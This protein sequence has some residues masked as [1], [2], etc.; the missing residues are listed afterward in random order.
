MEEGKAVCGPVGSEFLGQSRVLDLRDVGCNWCSI[1]DAPEYVLGIAEDRFDCP[2]AVCQ[3]VQRGEGWLRAVGLGA[4]LGMGRRLVLVDSLGN[5]LRKGVVVEVG[6]RF[7]EAEEGGGQAGVLRC[8]AVL[9]VLAV[10]GLPLLQGC[11]QGVGQGCGCGGIRSLPFT[12]G[13]LS[14]ART[15]LE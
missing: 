10:A 6:A 5:L 15:S 1:L 12:A 11:E 8:G 13:G 4:G 3:V 2:V 7:E 9:G 14:A